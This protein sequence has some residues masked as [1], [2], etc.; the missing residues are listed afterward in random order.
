[1]LSVR[2]P[3]SPSNTPFERFVMA[4]WNLH[5]GLSL[6]PCDALVY[7]TDA[8]LPSVGGTGSSIPDTL[9]LS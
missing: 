7:K 9:G 8:L 3:Q 5:L 2:T 6:G 1:M 4:S